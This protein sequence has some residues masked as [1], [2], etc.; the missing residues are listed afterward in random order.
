VKALASD[1]EYKAMWH[2]KAHNYLRKKGDH[3]EEIIF[4]KQNQQ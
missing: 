4:L 2:L 1:V 3:Q